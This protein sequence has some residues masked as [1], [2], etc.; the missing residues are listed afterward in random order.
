MSVFIDIRGRIE[1][2]Q[3]DELIKFVV[4]ECRA[5]NWA[6]RILDDVVKD[7]TIVFLP[8]PGDEQKRKVTEEVD[9]RG[10][11]H[12]ATR[13]ECDS[14]Y[15]KKLHRRG[16]RIWP[17][18]RCEVLSLIFDT[19]TGEVVSEQVFHPVDT[20][21]LKISCKLVQNWNFAKTVYA[22]AETHRDVCDAMKRVMERFPGLNITDTADYLNTGDMEH[23]R[24]IAN[25]HVAAVGMIG[26]AFESLSCGQVLERGDKERRVP[27]DREFVY[28]RIKPYERLTQTQRET[29]EILT[30]NILNNLG[31][32]TI[33]REN[34][35]RVVTTLDSFIERNR[36]ELK[37]A[38][39]KE[40]QMDLAQQGLAICFGDCVIALFGGYWLEPPEDYWRS[41]PF[42]L[43]GV[44]AARF[45]IDAFDELARCIHARDNETLAQVVDDI[46]FQEESYTATY[47]DTILF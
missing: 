7:V 17:H 43:A 27:P 28:S 36:E 37:S 47:N 2:E 25:E 32:S 18:Y 9:E 34:A 46:R 29:F 1:P 42:I 44:S 26:D 3:I 8:L 24:S 38:F 31:Y 6:Y 10:L 41:S 5:R 14:V 20:P 19:E 39:Q 22:G 33:N 45:S 12:R 30:Q 21:F 11:T 35:E 15:R 23:L 16:I 4:T 40:E 13:D